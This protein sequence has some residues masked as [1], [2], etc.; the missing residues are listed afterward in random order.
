[1][2][3]IKV[4]TFRTCVSTHINLMSSNK[5]SIDMNVPSVLYW[6]ICGSDN[7]GDR[8]FKK[9]LLDGLRISI[10]HRLRTFRIFF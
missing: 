5:I 3:Y 9:G 4:K 1:M 10:G 7:E 8:D 2:A 6:S